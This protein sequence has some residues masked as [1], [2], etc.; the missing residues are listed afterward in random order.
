[1]SDERRTPARLSESPETTG[2]AISRPG[3]ILRRYFGAAPFLALALF[4][5]L[6]LALSW[7]VIANLSSRLPGTATWAFDESTFVWNIWHFKHALLDLHASPLHSDLIWYPLGIKLVLYTYDFFNC[8]IAF[9]L[10]LAFNLPLATNSAWLLSTV[11]SGFG[12]YLL[13]LSVLRTEPP[14]QPAAGP[15]TKYLMPG[16]AGHAV[17]NTRQRQHL[18]ALLAGIIYAFASHRAVYAALGHYDIATTQWL[19]F[20]ALYLFRTLRRSGYRNPLLAGLFFALTALSEMTFATFLALLTLITLA[21][22]WRQLAPRWAALR[23]LALAGL[24]AALIWSPVLIPIGS[25]FITGDYA[26]TGWGESLKLSADLVGLVTP[27]ALNPLAAVAQGQATGNAAWTTALR[28]V[29]EGKARFSDINTVFLGY[30]T[31]A[32]ALLG[33]WRSRGRLRAWVWSALVFGVLSLGPLLQ[34]N[35]RYR[36]SLDNLLPEGIALPLPF[37]LLHFIP[38]INANRTPNRNGVVLMLALAVLAAWGA[39]WLFG[40]LGDRE[41]EK[42][43]DK[44]TRKQGQSPV[45]LSTRPAYGRVYLST[46]LLAALILLEHLAFPLPTTDA[47]IPEVYRQIAAEPGEFAIMQLPLG[48]RN[49]FGVLGSEQTNLQYFQTSHGKPMIGGN[50]SRAPAFK[51]A[52]FSRIPLFRAL[53]DLEMYRDVSPETDQA[54]RAQ[55][56][57]LMALYDVRYFLTTPPIPGRYPY[58]DTWQRTE[59]YALDVLPLEKPAAWEAEGYRV[60]RIIQPALPTPFRLDLGTSNREPYVG[61]GWDLRSDEQPFGATAIWATSTTA[62][63]YLPLAGPTETRLRLTVAPLTYAGAPPQTLA[64][65]VNGTPALAGQP[66]APGWQTIEARVPASATRRGPNR[67]SL[68]FGWAKS[69]RQV[70]PDAASRAVIGNTGVVSPVNLDVRSFNEAYI[71]AFAADG[72]EQKASV[73]RRGYNVAV[74]DARTGAVLDTRGFDTAANSYEADALADYLAGLRQGRI[75]ILATKGDATRHLTPAAIAGL[76]SLGSR[77]G[78]AG[79]LA[80]QAHALIGV[81]GA[82]PGSAAEAIGANDVF[83]RVAGDFRTLAAAVD[84][85]EVGP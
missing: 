54:A 69:P 59:A 60:Y 48:W 15:N 2:R 51:M 30:V 12:A 43:G 32:L 64:V 46:F 84:W 68:T 8:L 66:L 57:D 50:I 6:A 11:L 71:S 85:V 44:E 81:Q 16:T 82:I 18:A 58:Q 83:L 47:R 13:A 10:L 70:F 74:L 78:A 7:P 19:P 27:T 41:T 65:S 72:S 56:G 1:M 31:L 67:V 24:V 21:A 34:I 26:L 23:R 14:T 62:D 22:E 5:G 36:F 63:L 79:E 42:Q 9:P 37:A 80:G 38:V 28:A 53:T 35:G 33:V 75:V 61:D 29:E 73:G 52:Y 20:Y 25:E 45:Y 77:V 40:K 4:V 55:A 49:S 17:P 76:R 3:E 39:A